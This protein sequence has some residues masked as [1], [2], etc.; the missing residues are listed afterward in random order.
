ML[1][2]APVTEWTTSM[3]VVP[4]C[5]ISPAAAERALMECEPATGL[6]MVQVKPV[7]SAATFEIA[8]V[9]PAKSA[10]ISAAVVGRPVPVTVTVV[11][12]LELVWPVMLAATELN[13]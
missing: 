6:V 11:K 13:S 2:V 10:E 9:S 4:A 12:G 8:Q 1:G 7:P 5:L 3:A